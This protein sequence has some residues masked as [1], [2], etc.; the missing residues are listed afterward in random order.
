MKFF[1][2]NTLMHKHQFSNAPTENVVNIWI[3]FIIIFFLR[4]EII[5]KYLNYL[6]DDFILTNY[7]SILK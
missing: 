6:T 5:E 3:F 1:H 2:D 4:E 7:I